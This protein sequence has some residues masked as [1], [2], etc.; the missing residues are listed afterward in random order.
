MDESQNYFGRL[1]NDA[2]SPRS[3]LERRGQTCCIWHKPL[4]S[5]TKKNYVELKDERY[6]GIQTKNSILQWG[7]AASPTNDQSV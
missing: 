5:T 3:G 4:R 2:G 1:P 6:R 7:N